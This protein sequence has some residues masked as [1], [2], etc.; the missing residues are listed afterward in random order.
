M[1]KCLVIPREINQNYVLMWKQ[2]EVPFLA[3]PWIFLFTIGGFTGFMIT[4]L[5]TIVIAQTLKQFSIDKPNGYVTHWLKFNL[6][7]EFSK[8]LF[9]KTPDLDK[10]QSVWTRKETYPPFYI[11]HIA[12]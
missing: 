7:K 3:L 1:Q 10:P 5:L 4:A 11:R 9:S 2:D 8:S 6:P 12:G